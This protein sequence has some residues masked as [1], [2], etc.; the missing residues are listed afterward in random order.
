M[1]VLVV[2]STI[3]SPKTQRRGDFSFS[4]IIRDT[5]SMEE[6]RARASTSTLMVLFR[7]MALR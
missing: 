4:L 7:G 2:I 6:S 3:P 1:A 5:R